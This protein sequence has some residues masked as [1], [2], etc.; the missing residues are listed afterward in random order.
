MSALPKV[1][2][3]VP[4]YNHG[5]FI[6]QR[7]ESIVQ[8]TYKNVELIVID[9]CSS[10]ESDLV[11]KSLQ[12]RHGFNYIRNEQNSGT[13]FAAWE[14]VLSLV[15]GD[16]IWVCES[17]DFA[18]PEFLQ[19]A[20][21]ALENDRSA[22]LFYCHSW[23]VDAAGQRIDHTQSYFHQY[24][25]VARWDAGFTADG[26]DELVKFQLRGQ[27]VPNMSSALI[28][29]KAFRGAYTPYLKKFK[30]TGDW[31]FIGDV[32]RYGNVVFSN[33]ALN[34]FRRHEETARV[35]VNGA[36]E[37]AEFILTIYYLFRKTNCRVREFV[38]Y[39]AHPVARVISD[40]LSMGKV[41]KALLAISWLDTF[42][43]VLLLAV[44]IPMNIQKQLRLFMA[45]KANEKG[46]L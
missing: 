17:D 35:R 7:I 1:T 12:A 4:S 11:I 29:T 21:S 14:S 6:K 10:D 37:K 41:F 39:V 19:T 40:P 20:V 43:C 30:L 34:N 46:K 5:C 44:S 38:D 3:L 27:T 16:Y 45:G 42:R 26:H 28:S 36:A 2:A 15:T 25:K 31:I 22:V 8:Q 32:L 9:D 18:E 23:V 13:P 33:L 24:W